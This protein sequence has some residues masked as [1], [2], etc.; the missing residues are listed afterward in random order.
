[1]LFLAPL[2]GEALNVD[3]V[4]DLKSRALIH[5]TLNVLQE[6]GIVIEHDALLRHFAIGAGQEYQPREYSVPVT[7]LQPW[8]RWQ[9][10]P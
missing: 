5:V 6:A 4:D 3:V 8:R 10:V 1:M 2:I 7:I 9:R